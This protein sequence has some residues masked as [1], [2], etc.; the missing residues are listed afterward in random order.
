VQ[1]GRNCLIAGLVAVG[2]GVTIGDNTWIGP[3]VSI[4]E[5]VAIGRNAQLTLGSMVYRK[6]DDGKRVT[7]YFAE[8]HRA[9]MKDHLRHFN[10]KRP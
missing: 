7:G 2:G 1:I 6:V 5:R 4:V 10:R 9:F 3:S 8:D